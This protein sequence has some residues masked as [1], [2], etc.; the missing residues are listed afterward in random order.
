MMGERGHPLN[1]HGLVGKKLGLRAFAMSGDIRIVY[2][3]TEEAY[4]FLDVG[5]HN[6]VY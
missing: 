3:E 2:A 6:Q 5:S 4:V 1:D